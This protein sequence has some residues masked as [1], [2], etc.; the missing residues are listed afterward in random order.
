MTI[1]VAHGVC[2]RDDAIEHCVSCEIIY[3]FKIV[4][5]YRFGFHFFDTDEECFDGCDAKTVLQQYRLIF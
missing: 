1:K 4:F 2:H 5:K 3:F